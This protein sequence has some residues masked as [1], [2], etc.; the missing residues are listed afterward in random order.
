MRLYTFKNTL[1]IGGA[2][3]CFS[4]LSPVLAQVAIPGSADAGR[5]ESSVP[6]SQFRSS[7]TPQI[8]I[9][10][11][12]VQGAPEGADSITLTLNDINL[13]GVSAYDV[14]ELQQIYADKIG[15][16]ISLTEV[17]AIAQSI[18][19]KYRND[20]YIITQAV[21]PE[22]TIDNGVVTIRIVEGFIDQVS[23]GDGADTLAY[24][25]IL[26]FA[27]NLTQISPLTS[28][29]LEKWLLLVNDL[30][31]VSARSIISPSETTVGG[32]DLLIIPEISPYNF[33]LNVDNYGSRYLGPVQ[34]SGAAQF[35]N[36]FNAADLLEAQFV[37][38][39]SDDELMY[40]YTRFL[41]PINSYGSL[42]GLDVTYSDTRPGF[43]LERFEVEGY[44]TTYGFDLT[45]PFMRTR[46]QNLFGKLRFDYRD[47]SSGNV[48][49]PNKTKDRIAALRATLDY[50]V[51]DTIWRPAVNQF[52]MTLSKGVDVFR[53]SSKGDA[54]MTRAN[55]DPTFTKVEASMSRL[56]S[57]A[58]GLS[59]LVAAEGQWANNPLLSSE[60]FGVGGRTFGRGYDSS[61]LVGDDGVAAKVELQWKPDASVAWAD[62][63]EI[64]GFWDVGKI[65]NQEEVVSSIASRS[66][67]SAGLGLRA[68]FTETFSGEFT[69]A[70]PLTKE[71]DVHESRN[72]RFFFSIGADF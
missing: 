9:P 50:N 6:A 47:L 11:V 26:S 21:I 60:E 24:Q 68:D 17:Y 31:G 69:V 44:S 39:A 72:P 8:N 14:A 58:D 32:A 29:D 1:L 54:N 55:G 35:N 52:S 25:R 27:E 30:P 18:T 36:L 41:L 34:L 7:V 71:V 64:F 48:I 13:E 62:D 16:T 33:S 15:Q 10:E 40:A 63:Y 2:F 20:G 53:T 19:R 3:L 43:E 42:A 28:N 45:H 5:T 22:Q 67:A 51:F 49:D 23:L 59:V 57:V 12:S 4:S 38:D 65:W 46:T 61:E 70:Q 56:Q 66:L 37:T